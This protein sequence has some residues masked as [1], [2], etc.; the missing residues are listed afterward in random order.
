MF[1]SGDARRAVWRRNVIADLVA[2]SFYSHNAFYYRRFSDH[3]DSSKFVRNVVITGGQQ[4]DNR[5]I[6]IYSNNWNTWSSPTSEYQNVID[7]NYYY[8]PFLEDQDDDLG[9]WTTNSGSPTWTNTART[10]SWVRSNTLWEDNSTFN[11]PEF[12]GTLV[13]NDELVW[14]FIN[15]S[16]STHVFNLGTATFAEPTTADDVTGT[17]SVPAYSATVLYLRDYGLGGSTTVDDPIY[18]PRE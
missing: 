1:Q 18:N 12:A 5:G 13:D 11:D 3:I 15:W 16:S 9:I 4:A 6:G 17:L 2:V 14:C 8:N 10:L 7:S